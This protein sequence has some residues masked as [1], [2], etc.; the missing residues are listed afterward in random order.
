MSTVYSDDLTM[1]KKGSLRGGG[2]IYRIYI[3]VGSKLVL[4]DLR[5]MKR[6]ARKFLNRDL[7]EID[8]HRFYTFS[9]TAGTSAEDRA[10]FL[11]AV[12]HHCKEL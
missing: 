11:G 1:T 2:A 9:I 5:M 7:K 6:I 4:P 10:A 12:R 8:R 3:T